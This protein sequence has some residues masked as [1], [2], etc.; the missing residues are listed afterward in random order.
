MQ[1]LQS[2]NWS[3]SKWCDSEVTL[4][5]FLGKSIFQVIEAADTDP[6]QS[7]APELQM[8]DQRH[9]REAGLESLK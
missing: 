4:D 9:E 2:T 6:G 1:I 7:P 5:R 8:L 3:A